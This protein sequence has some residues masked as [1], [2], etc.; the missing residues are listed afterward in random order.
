MAIIEVGYV[1]EWEE[2]THELWAREYLAEIAR[3]SPGYGAERVVE[4]V[5]PGTSVSAQRR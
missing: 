2:W 3:R 5:A 1:G 4:R